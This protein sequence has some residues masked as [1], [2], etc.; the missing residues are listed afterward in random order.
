MV[1]DQQQKRAKELLEEFL[2]K[3][4]DTLSQKIIDAQNKLACTFS[5]FNK[6][7]YKREKGISVGTS[8][9]TSYIN[10]LKAIIN[11][12]H[13]DT[14][15]QKSF[16]EGKDINAV[17]DKI[18]LN[19]LR[20]IQLLTLA[21]NTI[22]HIKD[23]Y[24]RTS[25]NDFSN[26]SWFAYFLYFKKNEE[27]KEPLLGCA[28][29]EI[30]INHQV[31]LVHNIEIEYKNETTSKPESKEKKLDEDELGQVRYTGSYFPDND[32]N[33]GIIRFDLHPISEEKGRQ[34]HIKLFCRDK[35]QQVLVGQYMTY[36]NGR[37]LSGEMVLLNKEKTDLDLKIGT[38]SVAHNHE[39]FK[40]IP[41]QIRAFLSLR[42]KNYRRV[43]DDI[44]SLT[45]LKSLPK[46]TVRYSR[47]TLFL[48]KELP[49]LFIAYPVTGSH[50]YNKNFLADIEN[51][52]QE[53]YK[54]RIDVKCFK[55]KEGFDPKTKKPQPLKDIEILQSK[56]FFI[57][58]NDGIKNISYS[59]IQLG[60]ALL[61]CKIVIIIGKK[62][63]FSDTV[64]KLNKDFVKR[65]NIPSNSS[66][67]EEWENGNILKKLNKILPKYLPN[68]LDGT[69]DFS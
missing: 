7:H 38:F 30:D 8:A 41:K 68:S 21:E 50:S 13:F 58:M 32:M 49:E 33:N 56:R 17:I 53:N 47:S 46:K 65:I 4:G 26:T 62:I 66:L 40:I 31:S 44:S 34:L 3:E 55:D 48:E 60:W 29:I 24:Q 11:S 67:K 15:Y 1:N 5:D 36:E 69:M 43:R 2:P 18:N 59:Y 35:N 52:I 28:S 20:I 45:H 22:N 14:N 57:L 27:D 63:E 54:N 64:Q 6:K 12:P 37:I 10:T 23:K 25:K 19:K 42:R 39:E 9:V 61:T 16:I 51:K